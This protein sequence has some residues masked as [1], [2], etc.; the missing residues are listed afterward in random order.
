MTGISGEP[1]KSLQ[2][3]RSMNDSRFGQV[4]SAHCEELVIAGY[5]ATTAGM[6]ARCLQAF[7]QW[8]CARGVTDAARV[9]KADLEEYQR[10]LFLYR[11][12]DGKP[13]ALGTQLNSLVALRTFFKRLAKA[14]SIPVNPASDLELPRVGRRLPRSILSIAEIDAM[15]DRTDPATPRGLRDR[16][17]L[18]LLYSTGLRRMEVANLACG[19][20]DLGREAIFVHAGKGR[21]DRVVPM[22]SRAAAWLQRYLLEARPQLASPS[23]ERLFFTDYGVPATPDYVAKRVRR[24]K[25]LAGIEKTGAAHLLRHACATH[26]LE[27]GADIRFIQSLLGHASLQTTQ[28]YTHVSVEKLKAVHAATHPAQ[29]KNSRWPQNDSP[30]VRDRQQAPVPLNKPNQQKP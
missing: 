27:G 20:V 25:E 7:S 14:K 6:R 13:L 15:L 26:M 10:R 28:I 23:S 18:E 22:G 8:A 11:K 17:L 5:S 12:A 1:E 29:L 19:D 2:R 16:V 30:L 3:V 4:I 24:Y 21:V 9:S